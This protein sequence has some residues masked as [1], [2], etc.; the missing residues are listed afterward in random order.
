MPYERA[1]VLAS[2][3]LPRRMQLDGGEAVV[4]Y[5]GIPQWLAIQ[6]CGLLSLEMESN[7]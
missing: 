7:V 4:V 5:K 1:L 2:G 3:R 6:L